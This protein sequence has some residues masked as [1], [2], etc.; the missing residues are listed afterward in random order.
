MNSVIIIFFD[1]K[2]LVDYK[3]I[4]INGF[5]NKLCD[6]PNEHI[7]ASLIKD[8]NGRK[9]IA[10]LKSSTVKKI[11]K[12]SSDSNIY[13][14]MLIDE[15]EDE[16][17]DEDKFAP[18]LEDGITFLS[19]GANGVTHKIVYQGV[20]R[21]LKT[22]LNS[23]SDNL[24]YE[25]IVGQYINKLADI[26]P[27]FIKTH[28]IL[29]QDTTSLYQLLHGDTTFLTSI[30]RLTNKS[31][32]IRELFAESCKDV[33][34]SLELEYIESETL[35][36]MCNNEVFSNIPFRNLTE[37]IPQLESLP[38]ELM[39]VLY[40]IYMPLAFLVKNFNHRDLHHA[41]ILIEQENEGYIDY[42]YNYT[43]GTT[44]RFKSRY[45]ARIIDYGR[46]FFYDPANESDFG[47]SEKIYNIISSVVDCNK[48]VSLDF[49]RESNDVVDISH[50]LFHPLLH[51]QQR[52]KINFSNIYHLHDFLLLYIHF[53][54]T[55]N[56][57]LYQDMK[58]SYT[59][60]I[61]QDGRP[62]EIVY[63]DNMSE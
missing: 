44:I 28:G 20:T 13:S 57:Y 37:P 30:P 54:S 39:Y 1:E 55:Y 50:E 22:S 34:L 5:K 49:P 59:L 58:S 11:I 6:V 51:I 12:H 60:K 29:V 31:A 43:D 45:K 10:I 33:T 61:F 24:F 14:F 17:E 35:N 53:N 62:F 2:I 19:V 36:T 26:F 63:A 9:G 41:N 18:S 15:D 52:S 16:D 46:S 25:Y 47:S 4:Q 32:N 7:V 40:Q 38:P 23:K 21:I 48:L 56:T 27:C 8:K 3:D 42:E